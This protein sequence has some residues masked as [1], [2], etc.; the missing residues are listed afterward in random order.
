[1]IGICAA[2]ALIFFLSAARQPHEIANDDRHESFGA[3]NDFGNTLVLMDQ[4]PEALHYYEKAVELRPNSVIAHRFVTLLLKTGHC[5]EAILRLDAALQMDPKDV[6]ALRTLAWVLATCPE[7]S[8]R[9]GPKAVELA[10]LA[11]VCP[12]GDD[13][14]VLSALA[15]AYA[16][17]EGQFEDAVKT[18][19]MALRLAANSNLSKTL[20]AQQLLYRSKKPFRDF[21]EAPAGAR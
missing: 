18:M 21:S 17:T 9:R 6:T 15:A 13:P 12:G 16:E 1:M 4:I 14:L 10:L 5:Q 2:T 20:W 11:R 3:A 8:L 19:D 7:P